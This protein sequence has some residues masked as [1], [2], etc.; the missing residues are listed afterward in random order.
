MAA[1]TMDSKSKASGKPK[2][3]SKPKV[4]GKPKT[5]R[6]PKSSPATEDYRVISGQHRREKTE[7][8]IIEAALTVFAQKG[9]DAPVIEDFIKAAGVAR[10]T[11]YNFYKN[12]EDLLAAT[13]SWLTTD[14]VESIEGELQPIRDPALRHGVGLRLWLHK[15]ASD[16]AWCGFVSRIWFERVDALNAPLRDIRRAIKAGEFSCLSPECGWDVSLGVLRQAMIRLLGEQK[17]DKTAYC[18]RIVDAILKGLGASAQ[19]REEVVAY[20][21]PEMRPTKTVAFAAAA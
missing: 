18:D 19:K 21:L 15:A 6:K 20:P 13:S 5:T 12:T 8:K 11:F 16:P 9:R 14:L 7:A 10:G 3:S 2:T 17:L 1:A 4:S